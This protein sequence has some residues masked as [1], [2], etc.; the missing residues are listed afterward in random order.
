MKAAPTHHEHYHHYDRMW[1]HF[2]CAQEAMGEKRNYINYHDG[3]TAKLWE[4]MSRRPRFGMLP[5]EP[6]TKYEPPPPTV[7]DE[8]MTRENWLLALDALTAIY[9]QPD[10]AQQIA[11]RALKQIG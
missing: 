11:E 5:G 1:W 8:Q 10:C 2:G 6:T 7:R 3:P 4:E 9:N